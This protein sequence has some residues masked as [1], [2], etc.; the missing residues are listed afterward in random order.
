GP[1]ARSTLSR[2]GAHQ[3]APD[4]RGLRQPREQTVRT[5]VLRV[6]P[7]AMQRQLIGE[8]HDEHGVP[9]ARGVAHA[10]AHALD[11]RNP[12]EQTDHVAPR[13]L[14][15]LASQLR[16]YPQNDLMPDHA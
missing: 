6:T 3:I 5:G 9:I 7:E 1:K 15:D 10:V 13:A 12:L 14:D 8:V 2:L 4:R 11:P 16:A